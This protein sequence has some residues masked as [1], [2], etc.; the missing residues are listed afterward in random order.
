MNQEVH[1]LQSAV[2]ET[3]VISEGEHSDYIEKEDTY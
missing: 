3:E 2:E 1:V